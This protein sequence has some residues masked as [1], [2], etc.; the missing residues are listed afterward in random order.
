MQQGYEFTQYVSF[1]HIIEERKDNYYRALM[2]GQKNRY[3]KTE[4]IDQWILFFMD[5]LVTLIKRLET[6]YEQ[7]SKLK[8]DLNERQKEILAFIK[9][10]KK[11]QINEVDEAF[12]VYSRNTLKK[13]LAYLTN[14][15][16]IFKTGVSKGT[17]Y[18][19]EE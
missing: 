9:K 13:D 3:K 12:E 11:L 17:R 14:E 15:G 6:K 10:K 7:Y 18:H 8:K 4:K 5:C 2:D 1:E 16:L 19:Y